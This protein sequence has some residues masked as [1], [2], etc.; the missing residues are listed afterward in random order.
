MGDLAHALADTLAALGSRRCMCNPGQDVVAVID[1]LE[2]NM[3]TTLFPTEVGAGFAADGYRRVNPRGTDLPVCVVTGKAGAAHLALPLE[4]AFA[5]GVGMLVVAGRCAVDLA[6]V[7]V[8]NVE[9]GTDSVG[10][11]PEVVNA[12]ELACTPPQGP[13]L[14]TLDRTA[15]YGPAEAAP[16]ELT[17][18][19][20]D[21]S[22]RDVEQAADIIMSAER[23]L[24]LLGTGCLAGD[25]EGLR[26]AVTAIGVPCV[27]SM[28]ARGVVDEALELCLGPAGMRGTAAANDALRRA[29]AILVAGCSLS[30]LTVPPGALDDT[31]VF[32]VDVRGQADSG[33]DAAVFVKETLHAVDERDLWVRADGPLVYE[34]TFAAQVAVSSIMDTLRPGDCHVYDVGSFS[35]WACAAGTVREPGSFLMPHNIYPLGYAIPAA[36][37]ALMRRTRE[38]VVAVCGDGGFVASLASLPTAA[39]HDL[40]IV[41]LDDG[42]MDIIRQRQVE[43]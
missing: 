7:S 12:F 26:E 41:V 2:G 29:D 20:H 37:G 17:F 38:R 27:T 32:R 5:D 39:E 40:T 10:G 22:P 24:I 19:H 11:I 14:V 21:P 18:G 31:R 4:N 34:G 15:Q 9:L 36:I 33:A 28:P 8:A 43:R 23:P 1:A 16:R 35:M 42:G 3:E 25:V 6:T 30:H 13:V